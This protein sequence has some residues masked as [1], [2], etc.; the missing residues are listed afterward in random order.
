MNVPQNL[1]ASTTGNLN[2]T[3]NLEKAIEQAKKENKAVLVNFTGSDWC[4]WCKRL[5]AEVFQQKEFETYA[6]ENLVLVMLDFPKNI[7]QSQ[8]T[9][10]YNNMLA[11]KYGIQGFP[12]ILI[13]NNQGKMVA[14]TGYQPGG[15]S[16]YVKHIQS[17]L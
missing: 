3:S 7:E 11:Q 13:F 2:W 10:S 12:T 14:Q 16:N 6:K 5:S 17:Y 1:S 9:K 8:E 4:I 15:A